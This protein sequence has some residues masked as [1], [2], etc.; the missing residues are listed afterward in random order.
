MQQINA[1]SRLT[2]SIDIPSG[3]FPVNNTGNDLDAIVKA[4]E[5]LSLQSPKMSF[6]YQRYAPL[7]GDFTVINIH[8]L[9]NFNEPAFADY[10]TAA[11]IQ[12]KQQEQFAHKGNNGYLMLIG[13][14]EEMGGAIMLSAKAAFRTGCG[15]VGVSV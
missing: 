9:D 4:N 15:Y 1:G 5:T 13:G 6:F 10:L 14:L 12:L 11:N 7:V 2:I 3:L 8:L